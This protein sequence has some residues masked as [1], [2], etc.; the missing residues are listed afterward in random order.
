MAR[1]GSARDGGSDAL[2]LPTCVDLKLG[3][4]CRRAAQQCHEK[5]GEIIVWLCEDFGTLKKHTEGV[6]SAD[7]CIH[8][9]LTPG[10]PAE[11]RTPRPHDSPRWRATEG[12]ATAAPA[13]VQ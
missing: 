3:S 13:A 5:E 4:V 11:A 10:V 8:V 2:A 6:D 7:L 1:Q 12:A 9:V